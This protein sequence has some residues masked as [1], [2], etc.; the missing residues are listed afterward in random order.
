MNEDKI[1]GL[2]TKVVNFVQAEAQRT[3]YSLGEINAALGI[4]IGV[5]NYEFAVREMKAELPREPEPEDEEED[6]EEELFRLNLTDDEK[7]FA[8]ARLSAT[9]DR[10]V[11]YLVGS[12]KQKYPGWL[13]KEIIERRS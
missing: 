2:S 10:E 12:G 9:Y 3:D 7:L 4:A 5:L 13:K 6:E 1:A 8:Y 11:I